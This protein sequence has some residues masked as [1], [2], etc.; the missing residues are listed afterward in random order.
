MKTK[1]LN[2]L[3]SYGTEAHD[4]IARQEICKWLQDNSGERSF[5]EML[6][7]LIWKLNGGGESIST[8][9]YLHFSERNQRVCIHNKFWDWAQEISNEFEDMVHQESFTIHKKEL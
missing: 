6:Y 2:K 3:F 4:K 7:D 1:P 5:S 8:I 9:M